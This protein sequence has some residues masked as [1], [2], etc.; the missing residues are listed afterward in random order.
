[1]NGFYF[2]QDYWDAAQSLP[3]SQR[4]RFAISLVT[5]YFTGEE[6]NFKGTMQA[7][8]TLVKARIDKGRERAESGRRGG[9]RPK[10]NGKLASDNVDEAKGKLASDNA[11]KLSIKSESES[12]S[13]K[14]K[15]PKGVKK[16][17]TPPTP[18]AVSDFAA[19]NDLAIDAEKFCD[20]YEAQ[21]WKLSNGN[22]MRSWQ[23]AA[24]NWA[25]R[26]MPKDSRFDYGDDA[27]W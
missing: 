10:A 22:P 27:A 15:T 2:Q 7:M 6:P 12:E 9:T 14:E 19:D 16:K 23:A 5:Y 25:R 1:M 21:G 18:I 20:Y 11:G 3:K 24:R 4:E 26:S 8:F 17:F 13:E